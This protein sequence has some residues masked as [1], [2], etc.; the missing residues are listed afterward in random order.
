[1]WPVC[2][3]CN[4]RSVFSG[5]LNSVLHTHTRTAELVIKSV[6]TIYTG[7]TG[8]GITMSHLAVDLACCC[9]LS[10]SGPGSR[11]SAC[12]SNTRLNTPYTHIH[13]AFL[14]NIVNHNFIWLDFILHCIR[15][16]QQYTHLFNRIH[17]KHVITVMV[18]IANITHEKILQSKKEIEH[19]KVTQ[20]TVRPA[21]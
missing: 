9:P 4:A 10:T 11:S 3:T 8:A 6:Y 17:I 7:V 5:N 12:S 13:T 14:L 2:N 18:N 15:V 19:D 20:C 16:T 1:M 21:K